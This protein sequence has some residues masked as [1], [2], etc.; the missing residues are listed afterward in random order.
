MGTVMTTLKF[1]YSSKSVKLHPSA[2]SSN[3]RLRLTWT[4]PSLVTSVWHTLVGPPTA[5]P[6][7]SI[8]ILIVVMPET[9]L[10]S[11]TTAS[12]LI[13]RISKPCSKRRATSLKVKR[14]LSVLPNLPFTSMTSRR[15]HL[16]NHP[17][18]LLSRPS[19]KNW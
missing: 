10:L 5:N 6:L 18:T 4:R 17:S 7:P 3:N 8:L 14:T 15:T 9:N 2:H 11:F 13:T 12:S 1:S 16:S 19:L